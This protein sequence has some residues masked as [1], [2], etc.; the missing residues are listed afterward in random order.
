MGICRFSITRP[1]SAIVITLLIILFGVLS[2]KNL[3]ISEYPSVEVPTITI[4]TTYIGASASIV[5]TKITRPIE[6]AISGIEG[7]DNIQSTSKDGSSKV[8]VQFHISRDLD[9]ASNDVRDRL[10]K[11]TKN[12]PDNADSPIINKFDTSDMPILIIALTSDRMTRMELS[13]YA[14]RYICDRFS[15]IDGVASVDIPAKQEQAMR[16]WLNRKE[17]AARGITAE[18]VEKALE[19]ENVEFPAG[20][21]EST[22]KEYPITLNRAF[23]TPQD[24]KKIVIMED[25]KGHPVRIGDIAK[26]NIDAKSQRSNFIANKKPVVAMMINKQSKANTLSIA[27]NVKK[28]IANLSKRLPQGM[29]LV[30]LKDESKFI[31][32]SIYEV[33]FSLIIAAILVFI[34]VYLFIGSFLAALIPSLTV[35]ISIIGSCIVLNYQ[36]YSLNMLTLLAMVLAIGIVVDDAVLVLENIQRRIDDGEPPLLAAANGSNQVFFAVISTTV[37]LLTVFLPI[38]M[39]PGTL[40]KLFAEFSVAMSAAVCFSSL[41]ALTLTPMLCSKFLSSNKEQNAIIIDRFLLRSQKIYEKILFFVLSHLKIFEIFFIFILVCIFFTFKYIPGEYEPKEDRNALNVKITAQEGTGFYAMHKYATEVNAALEPLLTQRLAKNIMTMVPG[42]GSGNDGAVTSGHI[43]LDLVSL[44]NR[45]ISSFEIAKKYQK[46]LSKIPGIKI[47][48]VHPG[49][50]SSK[51]S[52]PLQFVIGGYDYEELQKWRDIIFEEVKNYKGIVDLDC[53]YKETTP[54]FLVDIDIARAG[55]LNVSAQ[56]IGKTLETMF[57]SKTTTTFVD[58][59]QEYDVILQAD[60]LSRANTTDIS[61]IYVRANNSKLIV[62]LDNVIKIRESGQA[63]KLGRHN[64]TRSITFSANIGNGYSLK[65]VLGY[66][67][68]TVKS[69]LPEYAQIYYR[70]QSKDYKDSEGRIIFVFIVAILISYF[71]LSAQFESFIS[72]FVIMLS[73]PL[74]IFGAI[75]MLF[76]LGYTLNIYSQ[77]GLIM[78]IGLSSKQGILI[79]E[80]ANQLR[81]EGVE[82]KKALIKASVLRLR[83]IIMTGFSTVAGAVP[84]ML[85]TGSG[86]ASRSN[87]GVVEV[88]G[89]ISGILLTLVIIPAGYFLFCGK[90][91]SP[92]KIE[93]Q[94][95]K[96]ENL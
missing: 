20:R 42:F 72:P 9:S 7:I 74:G 61:N 92:K 44:K 93:H 24:F 15:V 52:H 90:E 40:G 10:G 85:A 30:I 38:G 32:K 6:N 23:N 96:L 59:G 79:V 1:V 80:F 35:P 95:K 83:P 55:D 39:L 36:G 41:I 91:S 58:R 29:K 62:P 54:K 46:K 88:F 17:M 81:D 50:L 13:D 73:V 89:G 78:L 67:E 94:L 47:S 53:D 37:V 11:I 2:I 56:T 51:G 70:G 34:T 87:L 86:A 22:D 57:G 49:G 68:D 31:E 45:D 76:L 71:V 14:D 84:L 27:K 66:I 75:S 25:E 64:R 63:S 69:K 5:E 16:I 8:Q 33:F 18:D 43:M 21:I 26:I 28:V 82:F 65:D 77:I 48:I 60:T 3:P 4:S 12:L 19:L